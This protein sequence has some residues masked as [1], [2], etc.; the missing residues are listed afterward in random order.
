MRRL[1]NRFYKTI[2]ILWLT[3]SI[4]SVVL[5]AISWWNLSTLMAQGRQL[6]GIRDDYGGHS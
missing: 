2:V 6:S 5:A 1:G 4:G 3:L